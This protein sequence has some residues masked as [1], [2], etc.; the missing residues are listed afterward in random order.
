M[1]E[2]ARALLRPG[3]LGVLAT[4]SAGG[5]PHASLMA[6]ASD[7]KNDLVFVATRG[8]TVKHRNMVEN[9]R[10]S[11]LVDSR[12]GGGNRELGQV[13]ALT[14]AGTVR[15][16]DRDD[17]GLQAKKL[18]LEHHPDLAGFMDEPKVVTAAIMVESYL[19]AEG[20]GRVHFISVSEGT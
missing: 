17:D 14:L 18:L 2:R 12:I 6:Y 15:L 10:V 20:P 8:G 13:E 3:G 19:L 7:T 5:L 1:L 4:A 11:F 9:P 16:L